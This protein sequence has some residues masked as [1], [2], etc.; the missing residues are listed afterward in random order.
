MSIRSS[1]TVP[2]AIPL[3]YH[4]TPAVGAAP[5]AERSDSSARFVDQA[6]VFRGL[7]GSRALFVPALC[8]LYELGDDEL[9]SYRG[10]F[11]PAELSLDDLKDLQEEVQS[12]ITT[13]GLDR[14]LRTHTPGIAIIV[15]QNCNLTCSYCLAK[16]GTFGLE[17][18]RTNLPMVKMQIRDLFEVHPDIDF[19]KFFGGEPTLRMDLID[20][21]CRFVTDD[22]G[23]SV[24]FAVTTNGT[25]PAAAHIET[26]QRF[27]VSVSVSVDGPEDIHDR[28]RVDSRGHGSFRKALAYA[29]YLSR[30][31]F[32]FAV[33]GVFDERHIARG[34]SYLDTIRFLNSISPLTKVQFLE[35]LGAAAS[36][37]V[38]ARTGQPTIRSFIVD[39]VEQAV[40]EII[41]T[42]EAN[43]VN[44]QG[45]WLYDNNLMRFIYGVVT[46]KATPYK[47]AC[48]ASS[49]TTMFPGGEVMPCYT[50]SE[51]PT[52]HLGRAGNGIEE[53][54]D[55]RRT[56]QTRHSWDSLGA[57]GVRVPWYRGVVGDICVA[58]MRNS[59]K[60][61]VP[62][63]SDF[64]AVFQETAVRRTL[65]HLVALRHSSEK[66]ARLK[67]AV[68]EHQRITGEFNVRN[69]SL[70]TPEGSRT[71]L[72]S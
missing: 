23:K 8:R 30:N 21:I 2:P 39:Q 14:I 43:W 62:T 42:A 24:H 27:H 55:R 50:F 44:P 61:G 1:E 37:D 48:T 52:L 17:V 28:E 29:E 11:E 6:L 63:Q 20:D 15:T 25:L 64:Y 9:P 10:S 45:E 72:G 70:N 32:P 22:L 71:F 34:L 69:E 40:D 12:E 36:H 13:L 16:Q 54:E 19:I 60:D 46:A 68:V 67:H 66:L 5:S 47:H 41:K 33:V 4:R 51:D 31:N 18:S 7:D 58:D 3:K 35:T 65:Q 38:L 49:L 57:S 53:L 26:W 56:F 59:S